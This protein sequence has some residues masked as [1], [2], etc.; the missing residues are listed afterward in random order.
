MT[1]TT[2][3]VAVLK[4]GR[5][6]RDGHLLIGCQRV[7]CVSKRQWEALSAKG[8]AK[9]AG[10]GLQASLLPRRCHFEMTQMGALTDVLIIAIWTAPLKALRS[11]F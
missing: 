3:V 8:T 2:E 10:D 5:S 4:L 11:I 7:E 9:A 6:S 1:Q